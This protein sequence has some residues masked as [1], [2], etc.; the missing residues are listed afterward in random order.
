[1]TWHGSSRRLVIC[2]LHFIVNIT[3]KKKKIKKKK[4]MKRR[5]IRQGLRRV[6][7]ESHQDYIA[8]TLNQSLLLRRPTNNHPSSTVA[9]IHSS[10]SSA[11]VISP[12]ICTYTHNKFPYRGSRPRQLDTCES[13]APAKGKSKRK[14][15]LNGVC[16]AHLNKGIENDS[17]QS[18][19]NPFVSFQFVSCN[20]RDDERR[21]CVCV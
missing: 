7:L 20:T 16:S 9:A 12:A 19:T 14:K 1:M 10:S 4:K 8:A 3:Q 2:W 15:S 13:L 11:W 5:C 21:V 18:S 6:W 17:I